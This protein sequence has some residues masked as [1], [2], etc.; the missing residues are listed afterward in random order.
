MPSIGRSAP[1]ARGAL[2]LTVL[3]L[4]AIPAGPVAG[5]ARGVPRPRPACLPAPT[6]DL[7]HARPLPVPGTTPAIIDAPARTHVVGPRPTCP[8]RPGWHGR[9]GRH[10]AVATGSGPSALLPLPGT[11]APDADPGPV[12]DDPTP[13]PYLGSPRWAAD[14]VL[15]W[16]W[17]GSDPV[18]G[19]LREAALGAA[20]DVAR[21]RRSRAPTFRLDAAGATGTIRATT[22]FPDGPC[23]T[24]I[25]CASQVGPDGWWVRVRP[26]GTKLAWGTLRW[27][28]ADPTDGCLD[29]ER[30][31]IHE[32]G[33]VIGLDHPEN[34]GLHLGAWDSIMLRTTPSRPRPTS[35]MHAFAPCDVASLQ[36]RYDV[37]GPATP[38]SS[39]NDVAVRLGLG[40][41]ASGVVPGDAV[42]LVATLRIVRDDAYGKLAG[43]PLTGRTVELRRR[44]V[45]DGVE[46]IATFWMRDGANPGYYRLTIAPDED[47]DYQAV[48]HGMPGEGLRPV[49]SV[50]IAVRVR[51]DCTALTCPAIDPDPAA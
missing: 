35:S 39:C 44:T 20:D 31:L 4:A 15:G 7:R 50:P 26:H 30:V 38:I 14:S 10:P 23:A 3:L 43:N 6:A 47:A 41:T 21:S 51:G 34:A 28:Q 11:D 33:H 24:A 49:V 32:L 25:A 17:G 40:A 42:T 13:V 8:V 9:E 27:C 36:E 18:P 48:F 45:V 16:R 22:I 37:P 1:I 19:W 2:A 46:R 5:L 29:L 12:T